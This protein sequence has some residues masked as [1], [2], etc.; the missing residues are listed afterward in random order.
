MPAV[1]VSHD[2]SF[3]STVIDNGFEMRGQ[4]MQSLKMMT[5]LG[6]AR[7]SPAYPQPTRSRTYLID[8]LSFA[9][10]S[11]P[12]IFSKIKYRQREYNWRNFQ[13]ISLTSEIV[14]VDQIRLRINVWE[15][16][17][18]AYESLYRR[19][20]DA[21]LVTIFSRIRFNLC[22]LINSIRWEKFEN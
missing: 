14:L 9:D 22:A 10:H 17:D 12:Q 16:A 7:L 1:K 5:E 8:S 6:W 11:I 3:Y 21:I 4:S 15:L 19:W 2:F 18:I 13:R 20:P